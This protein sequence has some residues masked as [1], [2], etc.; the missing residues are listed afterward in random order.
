MDLDAAMVKVAKRFFGLSSAPA[1]VERVRSGRQRPQDVLL[2]QGSVL[3]E[4]SS[5]EPGCYVNYQAMYEKMHTMEPYLKATSSGPDLIAYFKNLRKLR[6]AWMVGFAKYAA[7]AI[8]SRMPDPNR[9]GSTTAVVDDGYDTFSGVDVAT[10]L[11]NQAAA[12]A[13]NLARK[14]DQLRRFKDGPTF[15]RHIHI[16]EECITKHKI[17]L[18]RQAHVNK[19]RSAS[20]K[21]KKDLKRRQQISSGVKRTS[22]E[23]V[24]QA[25]NPDLP[26]FAQFMQDFVSHS[27]LSSHSG[28][29]TYATQQANVKLNPRYNA[30]LTTDLSEQPYP[31]LPSISG[32]P[33]GP[34]SNISASTDLSSDSLSSDTAASMYPTP[35]DA[36]NTD[37]QGIGETDH[38]NSAYTDANLNLN[39]AITGGTY[40]DNDLL[41]PLEDYSHEHLFP[42]DTELGRQTLHHVGMAAEPKLNFDGIFGLLPNGLPGERESSDSPSLYM[43]SDTSQGHGWNDCSS[44]QQAIDA[45]NPA[46][47]L[48]GGMLD[49]R[50]QQESNVRGASMEA[51]P[52]WT[53]IEEEARFQELLF[54]E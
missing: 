32:L 42:D 52:V 26:D 15:V 20:T 5:N 21:M 2:R 43:S 12:L 30:D 24:K 6:R 44:S 23:P 14:D 17:H 9:L 27:P 34:A 31:D 53:D 18:K 36:G 33:D 45:I 11:K 4:I 10:A 40:G 37:L 7:H 41:M 22:A 28:D 1:L 35:C 3:K 19:S 47:L 50:E 16:L 39:S 8:V 13:R 54:G 46:L 48:S 49:L 29:M 38:V 25:Y 51:A